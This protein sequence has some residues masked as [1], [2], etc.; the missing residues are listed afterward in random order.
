MKN[1]ILQARLPPDSSHYIKGIKD[2]S[3]DKILSDIMVV[4]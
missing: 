2:I 1:K 4:F 3:E